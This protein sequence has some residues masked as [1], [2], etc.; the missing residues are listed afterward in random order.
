MSKYH[1]FDLIKSCCRGVLTL[2]LFGV[3]VASC[4]IEEPT[5]KKGES[6]EPVD[7]SFSISMDDIRAAME[8][9][10]P[11]TKA[12]DP[13]VLARVESDSIFSLALFLVRI[14]PVNEENS[15]IVGYRL[16]ARPKRGDGKRYFY[17]NTETHENIPFTAVTQGVYGAGNDDSS[18]NPSI[19]GANDF[20]DDFRRVRATFLYEHPMHGPLEKLT[21]GDEYAVLAV[22]NFV[23]SPLLLFDAPVGEQVKRIVDHWQ[24][25]YT[26]PGFVG[27]PR[28]ASEDPD[29]PGY[30]NWLSGYHQLLSGRLTLNDATVQYRY[31][32]TTHTTPQHNALGEEIHNDANGTGDIIMSPSYIRNKDSRILSSFGGQF[33]MNSGSNTINIALKRDVS[34]ITVTLNSESSIP[35]KVTNLSFSP[36][37]TAAASYLFQRTGATDLTPMVWPTQWMG[38]PVVSS[39]R[40]IVPFVPDTEFNTVGESK[41]LFDALT[42]PN[43]DVNNQMTMTIGLASVSSTQTVTRLQ[44]QTTQTTPNNFNTLLANNTNWP[45]GTEK[46]FAVQTTTNNRFFRRTQGSNNFQAQTGVTTPSDINDLIEDGGYNEAHIWIFKKVNGGVIIRNKAYPGWIK[47]TSSSNNNR[48]FTNTTVESDATVLS[49]VNNGG[50]V[51]FYGTANDNRTFYLYNNS[52]NMAAV[53]ANNAG[54]SAN[55]RIYAAEYV[56]V[57]IVGGGGINRTVTL[58]LTYFSKDQGVVLPLHRIKRNQHLNIIVDV[59]YSEDTQ[60]FLF[61][62]KDWNKSNN[63]IIF[64]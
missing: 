44:V 21:A 38:A 16:F 51:R 23:E 9:D 12:A 61:E 29:N 25:R 59:R 27:I 60:E 4:D 56:D 28:N 22:A 5:L 37:V 57:D 54:N 1:I 43:N 10:A 3:V 39:P 26:T 52:G 7:L 19:Y 18:Y 47:V 14:D 42:L 41:V 48:T 20:E 55:F 40:A 35:I 24:R 34:R 46:Y 30:G 31:G 50:N 62:V 36:N 49:I 15:K 11:T 32:E 6:A 8:G 2:L 13:E 17:Y 64:D 45:L 63:T 33:L 58:P 53:R